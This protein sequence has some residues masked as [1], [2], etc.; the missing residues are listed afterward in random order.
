VSPADSIYNPLWKHYKLAYQ[1]TII[2]IDKKGNE[3][4]RTVSYDGNRD[5]YL[6]FM[7]DV[8]EGKNLYKDILEAYQKDTLN[9]F[10]NYL[11]AK[12]LLFNYE[13]ENANRHFSKVLLY[14]PE[15]KLGLQAECKFKIAENEFIL[16]GN[17]DKMWEY[18]KTDIKNALIPKA[19]EYLIQDLIN[20][21][22]KSSCIPLCEEGFNKYPDSWE[23]LNKYAWA[24]CT[25]KI[26][27]D[28]EK[29]L[30]MA[31]KSIS[32]NPGRAGTYSTKAW[33]HFEMGD[34]EKAIE[35]QK[36]AIEIYPNSSFNKDLEI[37]MKE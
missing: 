13:L 32:L 29:A 9:A 31:Q 7:K 26:M 1:S 3:I 12:K 28:Y 8:S 24:I 2:Y 6:N 30:G 37:F 16:T 34:K 35:L 11:L 14:D 25:F 22:D 17:L 21:K 18:I 15:D 4:D 5:A 10:N 36:M 20:K 27:D 23:I 19:Y 33:I